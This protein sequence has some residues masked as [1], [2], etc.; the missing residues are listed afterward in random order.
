MTAEAQS[1]PLR[2]VPF[3]AVDIRSEFWTIRLLAVPY[4]VWGNRELG[5][6]DVWLLEDSKP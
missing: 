3:S 5:E 6:M 2:A 4:A 1:P